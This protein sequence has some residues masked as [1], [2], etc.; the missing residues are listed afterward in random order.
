M[1]YEKRK[2]GKNNENLQLDESH[3]PHIIPW[4]RAFRPEQYMK[5]PPRHRIAFSSKIQ[6]N[7]RKKCLYLAKS[8]IKDALLAK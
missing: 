3:H 1:N 6:G 5:S 2:S 4:A 7:E 8:T